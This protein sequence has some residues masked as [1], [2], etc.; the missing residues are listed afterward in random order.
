MLN[1]IV[2]CSNE[3]CI[4]QDQEGGPIK[5]CSLVCMAPLSN[6]FGIFLNLPG[7]VL[8]Q[9]EALNSHTLQPQEGPL[10][11][12]GDHEVRPQVA[13]AVLGNQVIFSHNSCTYFDCKNLE[14]RKIIISRLIVGFLGRAYLC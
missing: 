4:G 7:L 5:L 6:S 1:V 12:H 10:P 8:L 11:C 14:E 13:Q 9:G 3:H 2:Q